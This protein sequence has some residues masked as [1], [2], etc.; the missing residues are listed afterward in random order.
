MGGKNRRSLMHDI[1]IIN[2]RGLP[3]ATKTTTNNNSHAF[4]VLWKYRQ[5]SL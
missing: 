1:R 2:N 4:H 5:R 3:A